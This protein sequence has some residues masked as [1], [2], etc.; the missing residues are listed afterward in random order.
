F[1]QVR[2]DADLTVVVPVD[3]AGARAR[4]GAKLGHDVLVEAV[5]DAAAA[6]AAALRWARSC[7]GSSSDRRPD[8][9]LDDVRRDERRR[10]RGG[11]P[12]RRCR[13]TGRY[14]A[15]WSRSTFPAASHS[16][17]YSSTLMAGS[18]VMET[19]TPCSASSSSDRTPRSASRQ[20]RTARYR[21]SS[22]SSWSPA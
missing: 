5:R 7:S 18:A 8:E 3:I 12:P 6:H 9:P 22:A 2:A 10:S 15:A 16:A 1:E 11:S 21:K 14:W 4:V 20:H 13:S 17:S 19:S